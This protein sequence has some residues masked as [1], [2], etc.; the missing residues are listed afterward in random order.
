MDKICEQKSQLL[1]KL[2]NIRYYLQLS[3]HL[4]GGMLSILSMG[5]RKTVLANR[6]SGI[7]RPHTTCAQRPS[8]VRLKAPPLLGQ[9]QHST[10]REGDCRQRRHSH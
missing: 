9:R 2:Y 7:Q 1:I 6:T 8:S 4:A 5:S 10:L 3:F